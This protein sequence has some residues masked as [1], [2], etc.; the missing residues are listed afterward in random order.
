MTEPDKVKEMI[1]QARRR[2]TSAEYLL[3]LAK[4]LGV[5]IPQDELAATLIK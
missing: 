4:I 1:D 2:G 5:S 3:G